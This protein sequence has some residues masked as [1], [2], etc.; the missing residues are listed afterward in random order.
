M[1]QQLK[2]NKSEDKSLFINGNVRIHGDGVIGNEN[3][4][5][6]K[7]INKKALDIIAVVSFIAALIGIYSFL[8]Q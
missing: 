7:S 2:K 8:V 5:I 1:D 3:T 4:I 6:K